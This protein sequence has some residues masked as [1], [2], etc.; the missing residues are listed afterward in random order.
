MSAAHFIYI[1]ILLI[2]GVVI[3]FIL[4]GRAARDAFNLQRKRDAELASAK[5]AREARRKER[6]AVDGKPG[7]EDGA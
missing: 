5:A 4:G 7:S 2:V 3:G 1:P 6:Q